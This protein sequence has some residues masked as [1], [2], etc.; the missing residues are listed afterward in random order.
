M[1]FRF[2]DISR[3]CGQ[4]NF[5]SLSAPRWPSP[6]GRSGRPAF[7]RAGSARPRGRCR[8]RVGARAGPALHRHS[9]PGMRDSLG[10]AA[11]NGCQRGTT[12]AI[13]RNGS[14]RAGANEKSRDVR[15]RGAAPLAEERSSTIAQIPGSR[16]KITSQFLKSIISIRCGIHAIARAA[17][18]HSFVV[19]IDDKLGRESRPG[20]VDHELRTY[21]DTSFAVFCRRTLTAS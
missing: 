11:W 5:P 2:C 14:A 8:G 21:A 19:D 16:K 13:D 15:S 17:F 9:A 18:P 1:I 4:E 10:I 6:A 3:V 20:A 7:G 12:P